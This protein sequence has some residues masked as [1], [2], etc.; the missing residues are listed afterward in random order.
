MSGPTILPTPTPPA[1]TNVPTA[2][3]SGGNNQT[4]AQQAAN[5]AAAAAAQ[6]AAVS[7]ANALNQSIMQQKLY[8]RDIINLIYYLIKDNPEGCERFNRLLIDKVEAFLAPLVS[9]TTTSTTTATDLTPV[10]CN[11]TQTSLSPIRSEMVL[12]GMCLND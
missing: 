9:S 12:L 7:N 4:A 1:T 11:V 8:D 3:Q 5:A 10:L 6:A 2:A